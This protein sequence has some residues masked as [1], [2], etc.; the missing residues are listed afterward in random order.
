[1]GLRTISDHIMDI[2]QN[3]FNAGATKLTKTIE[4]NKNWFCFQVQ[5]NGKGMDQEQLSRIFDPFYTTRDPRI[6]RVGLGLP[7]L[8]Q[9][10]EMTGGKIE[11]KS[12]KGVGTIVKACFDTN[13]VDCQEI[14]DLSDSLSTLLISSNDVE[15]TVY[16]S[17]DTRSYSISNAEL[18]ELL[19]DLSSPF[20][21]KF[22]YQVVE[23]LEKSVTGEVPK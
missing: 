17:K 2:V 8:K 6:R 12:T 23:E 13:H 16:R 21:I 3:S 9:A 18:R 10:A 1:M 11:V 4:Q 15:L 20:A 19:K 14:G 7:F 5:D 22:V